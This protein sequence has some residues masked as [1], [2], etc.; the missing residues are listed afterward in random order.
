MQ[1][2]SVSIN[3][4]SD[5]CYLAE[6]QQQSIVPCNSLQICFNV[7]LMYNLCLSRLNLINQKYSNKTES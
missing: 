7:K 6:K 2:A 5:F 3:K 1:N 4:Y